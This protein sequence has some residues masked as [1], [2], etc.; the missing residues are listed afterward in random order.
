MALTQLLDAATATGAGT[1]YHF[2]DQTRQKSPQAIVHAIISNT[3]TAAL[4][5]SINGTDWFT[6]YSFTST[7]AQLIDLPPQV[8]G[9][10]TAY[11]SGA[12]S[13]VLDFVAR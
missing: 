8:R 6:I 1:T 4:Q 9:N 11:T 13:M 3:A 5:G 7:G 10:V 2:S 12:V